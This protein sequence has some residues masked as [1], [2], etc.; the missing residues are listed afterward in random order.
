MKKNNKIHVAL[1]YDFDSTLSR[2]N[3]QDY[4]FIPALN[5]TEKSF[6]TEVD[7]VK[8]EHNM[9]NVLAYM[10]VMLMMAKEK[11]IPVTESNFLEFGKNVEFFKRHRLL[12]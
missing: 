12:V 5:M 4:D 1:M 10:Y 2:G 8:Y 11:N 6:W 9:D 7:K 3:I